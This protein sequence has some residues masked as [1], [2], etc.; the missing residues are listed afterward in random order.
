L[1]YSPLRIYFTSLPE[2]DK[3]MQFKIEIEDDKGN[4]FSAVTDSVFITN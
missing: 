1:G 2:L 3:T 4:I